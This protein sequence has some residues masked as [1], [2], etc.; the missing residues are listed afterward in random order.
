MAS[1]LKQEYV[2]VTVWES[3]T[4]IRSFFKKDAHGEAMRSYREAAEKTGTGAVNGAPFNVRFTCTGEELKKLMGP[5]PNV[6]RY[7][8]NCRTTVASK[9]KAGLLA[10]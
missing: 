9:I 8:K 2:W 4:G 1:P 3:E 7:W 6:L 10:A 5:Y